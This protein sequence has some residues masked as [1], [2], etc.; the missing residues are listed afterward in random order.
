MFYRSWGAWEVVAAIV[1]LVL[2]LTIARHGHVTAA[3]VTAGLGLAALIGYWIV[4]GAFTV[5][6]QTD[7]HGPPPHHPVRQQFV[8]ASWPESPSVRTPG[9]QRQFVAIAVR[10]RQKVDRDRAVVCLLCLSVL[11][12]LLHH[13]TRAARSRSAKC[14]WSDNPVRAGRAILAG[15]RLNIDRQI[16]STTRGLPT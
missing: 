5:Q 12:L 15:E 2:V 4:L 7:F 11:A 1:G 14:S 16:H 10:L 6:M 8:P 9:L 3:I 13:H